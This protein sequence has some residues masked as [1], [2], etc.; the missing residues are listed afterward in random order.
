MEIR[1][2]KTASD[3]WTVTENKRDWPTQVDAIAINPH[4]Y[5]VI[6]HIYFDNFPMMAKLTRWGVDAHMGKLFGMANRLLLL[7][8]TFGICCLLLLG[9]RMWWIR[10]P[11]R[12]QNNPLSTLTACWLSLSTPWQLLIVTLTI[13]LGYCLPVLGASL[14]V[15]LFIDVL[16]WKKYKKITNVFPQ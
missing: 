16:L 10:R 15:F 9:Y 6:D 8:F 7:G 13:M 12:P 3:A 2:P 4:N 11:S 14:L 5:K 1:Q